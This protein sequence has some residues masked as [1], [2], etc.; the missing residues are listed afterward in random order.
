VTVREATPS[1]LPAVRALQTLLPE[2]VEE[3]FADGLPPGITFVALPHS[4]AVATTATVG[5][6][7]DGT[8]VG[9]VHA[10]DTGYVSEL[11]V[12][13]DHR[14][15]GHGRAL[16]ARELAALRARD[17]DT[18]ELEVAADNDRARSL[19]E[20]LGFDVVERHPD[21][22]DAGDGLRMAVDLAE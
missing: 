11:A 1:D 22:Y 6:D 2:P 15:R 7:A 12:A 5:L 10:Y 20:S 19:Y 13:P 21:R 9:Y 3:L 14:G 16:L 8:P 18:A 4:V 17:V